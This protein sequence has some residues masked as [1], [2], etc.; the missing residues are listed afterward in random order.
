MS[1]RPS[2]T[3]SRR[4]C[5]NAHKQKDANGVYL[6]CHICQGRIDPLRESWEAE[7][8]IPH[9]FGGEDLRPAHESCHR[10]KTSN[11]DIP[12]IA[13]S[14]RVSEKHFGIKKKGWGGKY[15]KK[16]SGEIVER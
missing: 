15:R 14:K 6:I 2:S 8:T 4:E 3:K 13:K 7:H 11:Q 16:M 5:F 10:V 12:A 1:K 9:A